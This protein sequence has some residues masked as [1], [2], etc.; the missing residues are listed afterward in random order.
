MF[1]HELKTPLTVISGFI[2]T[3]EDMA[4]FK[5]KDHKK[6]F[7]MMG[8]QAYRMT[9]LVDDLLLLSNVESNLFQNRSEKLQIKIMINK[10]KKKHFIYRS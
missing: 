6:I 4:E 2:E 8:S 5:N 1:S 10:I 7:K 9:K 3:L